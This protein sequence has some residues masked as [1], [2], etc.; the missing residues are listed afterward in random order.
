MRGLNGGIDQIL[1]VAGGEHAEDFL[2]LLGNGSGLAI[3]SVITATTITQ[4]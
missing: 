1:I 4:R 2:K 3:R